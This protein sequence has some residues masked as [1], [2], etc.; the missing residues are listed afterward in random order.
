ML[1]E[2]QEPKHFFVV[3]VTMFFWVF[4]NHKNVFVIVLIFIIHYLCVL[5]K[6]T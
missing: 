6:L 1:F 5:G 3:N 4:S 2:K